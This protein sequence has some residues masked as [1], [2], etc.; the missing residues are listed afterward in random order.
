MNAIVRSFFIV[1]GIPTLTAALYFGVFAS[2][3]YVSEARFSIRSSSS[4]GGSSSGDYVQSQDMLSKIEERMDLR[5]HYASSKNDVLARLNKK[6]TSEELLEYTTK[7][8]KLL[9]DSSSDVLT[10]RVHAFDPKFSM[11]LASLVIEL[12]EELVNRLSNRIEADA[13]STAQSEVERLGGKWRKASE[14]LRKFR[15]ENQSLSP[16]SESSSLMG[17]VSGIEQKLLEVRT[18]LSE[19]GAFMRSAAPEMVNLRNREIAL[20]QQLKLEKGR[21]SGEGDGDNMSSLIDE[22]QPLVL[23]QELVQQQYASAL[24]SLEVARLEAQRKKQY[25]VTFIQPSLPDEA[26][27]P[28]RLYQVLTVFFSAFIAYLIGGL[29][30][31]ALR[32]HMRI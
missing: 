2:D 21:V 1:C 20:N 15:N 11:D 13:L 29:M 24:N 26:I 9:Q 27:E 25:L 16:T 5:S 17:M 6:A 32:D 8:I 19:K 22:Y 30:W 7:H 28:R 4:S 31:S 10:L 3:I 12:S 14:T 23:E 18:E